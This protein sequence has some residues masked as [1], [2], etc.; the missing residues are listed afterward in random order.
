MH[1]KTRS[2]IRH[3]DHLVVPGMDA[4]RAETLYTE[5]LGVKDVGSPRE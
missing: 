3:L 1:T 5:V 4:E 2:G